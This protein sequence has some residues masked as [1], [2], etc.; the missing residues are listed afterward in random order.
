VTRAA[1]VLAALLVP[2]IAAADV[3]V[4]IV[5]GD[6]AGVGMNDPT[7]VAPVG[8]NPG[9]TLGQ[10]RFNALQRAADLWGQTLDSEV[11]IRIRATWA[12]RSCDATSAVL[13]SCGSNGF[14]RDFGGGI[15]MLENTWYARA[16]AD[17][18][19]GADLDPAGDADMVATFNINIGKDDCLENAHWYYGFDHEEGDSGVDVVGTAMHEFGHGLG[20]LSTVDAATGSLLSGFPDAYARF[21]FDIQTNKAWTAM[22]NA[23]R[24]ASAIRPRRVVFTG[25]NA[26]AAAQTTL[27]T[28]IP[29][30][31]VTAPGSV[32]G[33]YEVVEGTLSTTVAASGV[34]T[35]NL[36]VAND[37]LFVPRTGDM[38]AAEAANASAT[39]GCGT[40]KASMTGKIAIVD[41]G[42]CSFSY[43]VQNAQDSGAIAVI[44][45]N[46]VAGSPSVMVPATF[47]P[48]FTTTI[49]AVMVSQADGTALKNAA[50]SGTVSV[51]LELEPGVTAGADALHR[52]FVNT[53]SVLAPGSSVS[54]WDPTAIPNLLMEP[55]ATGDE[56]DSVDMTLP[57]FRDIGWYGDG[58]LDGLPDPSDNCPLAANPEQFDGDADGDGDAC[59]N[60]PVVPNGDQA[61]A[62]GDSVGDACDNDDDNDTIADSGD[63]CP[64]DAN[65]DQAD[66]DGDGVGDACELDDDEDGI[67]DADDNC[68]ETANPTQEDSDGDGDGDAC[69]EDS[70]GDKIPDATDNCPTMAN[71]DQDDRDDDGLGDPCDSKND[72]GG[73]AIAPSGSSSS[74]LLWLMLLS[75]GALLGRR[76]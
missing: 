23:E 25:Q 31:R 34:K 57:A 55:N 15:G 22:S 58:D 27:V 48:P 45:V 26:V 76:R 14:L 39:D 50:A 30:L 37:N 19:A 46:N 28:P 24:M 7:A 21:L 16:L 8:G 13:A 56:T 44:V 52:P 38:T 71:V 47:T 9:T 54:H 3:E 62:D 18:L 43:K 20:F 32:D 49:P 68:P 67:P 69:D 10:Q 33:N 60:C 40:N 75:I 53:P 4:I 6:A 70:D 12:A 41:R 65:P 5:N 42:L 1:W 35:A 17:R 59:D 74:G 64:T 29:R 61:N 72:S 73:C 66:G 11:P 2:T 63:N 36:Q 51:V